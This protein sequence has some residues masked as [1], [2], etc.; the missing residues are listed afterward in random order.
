[1]DSVCIFKELTEYDL[2]NIL[3]YGQWD[4]S[5]FVCCTKRYENMQQL[6]ALLLTWYLCPSYTQLSCSVTEVKAL[7]WSTLRSVLHLS[8]LPQNWPAD[9]YLL[10]FLNFQLTGE[11]GFDLKPKPTPFQWMSETLT[12]GVK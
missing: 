3:D 12:P 10:W 6:V 5:S 4:W 2:Q 9:T 7:P 11:R 1:M 8:P